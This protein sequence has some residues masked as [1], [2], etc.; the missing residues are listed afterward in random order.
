MSFIIAT[1]GEIVTNLVDNLVCS[2]VFHVCERDMML[3]RFGTVVNEEFKNRKVKISV[4]NTDSNKSSYVETS[5]FTRVTLISS[6][7]VSTEIISFDICY[8]THISLYLLSKVDI[9]SYLRNKTEPRHSF[10]L[11]EL[12]KVKVINITGSKSDGEFIYLLNTADKNCGVEYSVNETVD[13]NNMK[14]IIK[15]LFICS[16]QTHSSSYELEHTKMVPREPFP[17]R[18]LSSG[19]ARESRT[20]PS[21]LSP[22]SPCETMKTS[23]SSVPCKHSTTQCPSSTPFSLLL[24]RTAQGYLEFADPG[25]LHK[26]I[27]F[28]FFTFILSP[29]ATQ[30][31]DPPSFPSLLA[32]PHPLSYLWVD[33]SNNARGVNLIK[34]KFDDLTILKDLKDEL[35]AKYNLNFEGVDFT[36]NGRSIDEVTPLTHYEINNGSYVLTVFKLNGGVWDDVDDGEGDRT[37]SARYYKYFLDDDMSPS[38]W[39]TLIDNSFRRDKITDSYTKYD[40]IIASLPTE[41]LSKMSRVIKNANLSKT[42]YEDLHTAL[43]E[44]S[45]EPKSVIFDRYFKAQNMGNRKPSEF[46]DKCLKELKRYDTKIAEDDSTLRSFFLSALPSN[47]QMILAASS[48]TNLIELASIADK[49]LEVTNNKAGVNS[50]TPSF[51]TKASEVPNIEFE[52]LVN[53]IEKMNKRFDH[54]ES[55]LSRSREQSPYNHDNHN[56]R[57]FPPSSSSRYNSSNNRSLSPFSKRHPPYNRNQSERNFCR[58]HQRY[59][60]AARLCNPG[61]TWQNRLPECKVLDTCIFHI[62]Y[63]EDART[64]AEGCKHYKIN[65]PATDF[66][67][68]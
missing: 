51:P 3:K 62:R 2:N 56:N 24:T 37:P 27:S 66:S 41:M 1:P 42:P 57:H 63:R 33:L 18:T 65:S 20:H 34:F 55:R 58:F 43:I 22:E 52:Y 4:Q 39:L 68:N 7:F 53:S 40:R 28:F 38:T 61:C 21:D 67:K 59:R 48:A 35:T 11:G 6:T 49:I 15:S 36:F 17:T 25:C 12:I 32:H 14:F 64:C 30:T 50:T 26:G 5:A 19:N 13:N 9:R 23:H 45:N 46:L 44:T 60:N 54:L 10:G 31:I 29:P 8:F 16:F 47:V